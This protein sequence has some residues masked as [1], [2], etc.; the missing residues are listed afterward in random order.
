M[1]DVILD[2]GGRLIS[3]CFF[4]LDPSGEESIVSGYR[5][6]GWVGSPRTPTDE[7]LAE[8]GKGNYLVGDLF[9][10]AD[11]EH[12]CDQSPLHRTKS[13]WRK[14]VIEL[15]HGPAFSE[16]IPLPHSGSA[17]VVTQ[18]L[19]NRLVN[20]SFKGFECVRAET[21]GTANTPRNEPVWVVNF[22]G[23]RC[24]R[25]LRLVGNAS[26]LCY[27][28]G[29]GPV[30]CP[31]CGQIAWKCPKCDGHPVVPS[32]SV[33][34]KSPGVLRVQ[35]LKERI[36]NIIEGYQWDGSDFITGGWMFSGHGIVTRRVVDWLLSIHVTPFIAEPVVVDVSQMSAA[37]LKELARV[38]PGVSLKK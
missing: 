14:P 36:P 6:N 35:D 4:W 1:Y 11:A 22:L 20:E 13:R 33:S 18:W 2:R 31:S 8:Q 32:D 12:K 23:E 9:A 3:G 17:F 10:T 37:Q 21:S 30:V 27:Q 34:E 26:N 7:E 24:I 29:T 19:R 28:C 38:A 5:C 15:R 25:P 16:V